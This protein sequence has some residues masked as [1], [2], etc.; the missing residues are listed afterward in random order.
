VRCVS[1]PLPSLHRR[2][3]RPILRGQATSRPP[4]HAHPGLCPR[5]GDRTSPCPPLPSHRLLGPRQN[6]V[7]YSAW[8][9]R[10]LLSL[11]LARLA[12]PPGAVCGASRSC[13]WALAAPKRSGV[14]A[15]WKQQWHTKHSARLVNLREH[16]ERNFTYSCT[17]VMCERLHYGGRPM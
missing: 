9:V 5:S 13:A 7:G 15:N 14:V 6:C 11:G 1:T 10:I 17:H 8:P 12:R 2:Y 4:H 16:T 3:R